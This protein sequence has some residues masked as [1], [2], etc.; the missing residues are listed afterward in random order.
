MGYGIFF[1]GQNCFSIVGYLVFLILFI[2]R[3][4]YF[5]VI[6]FIEY[7]IYFEVFFGEQEFYLEYWFR[8]LIFKQL[9]LIWCN[10]CCDMDF[11][12]CGYFKFGVFQ[13]L[14]ER[15]QSILGFEVGRD[16]YKQ[17]R[18]KGSLFFRQKD[19]KKGCQVEGQYQ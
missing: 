7:F 9:I 2:K 4:Q 10:V 15:R 8:G 13:E 6:V 14:G 12:V 18:F 17:I 19:G 16:Y 11:R 5:F 3:K 1:V